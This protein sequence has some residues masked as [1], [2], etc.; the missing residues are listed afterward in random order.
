M[1]FDDLSNAFTVSRYRIL[2]TIVRSHGGRRPMGT[3]IEEK[4]LEPPPP[5]DAI[6]WW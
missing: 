1:F 4:A 3:E 5:A 6:R 2:D